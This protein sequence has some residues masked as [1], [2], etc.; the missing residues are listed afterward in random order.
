M[1]IIDSLTGWKKGSQHKS[2]G[3]YILEIDLVAF[4]IDDAI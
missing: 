1:K 3:E 4:R 2:S